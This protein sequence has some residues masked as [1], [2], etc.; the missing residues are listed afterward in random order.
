MS[1]A[2]QDLLVEFD[3][4]ITWITLNRPTKLN[5]LT[6]E[7]FETLSATL[8]SEATSSSKV[9]IIKGAGGN[10]S[11]GHDLS[12]DSVEVNEPGDSL[13]DLN[14]QRF[15]LSTFFQIFDHPKPVIAAVDGY[16]IA[17][18]TQI[19]P[20][21]D[22]VVTSETAAISGSPMIPLGGGFITPLL[23]YKI[24]ISR[25][26]LLSFI[27]GKSITGKEAV[28][29]GLAVQSVPS[30]ELIDTVKSLALEIARTPTSVLSLKKMAINRTLVAQGFRD[31]AYAGAE[32]DVVIHGIK[33][34][35]EYKNLIAKDG[36]K[37]TMARFK[38]GE[39]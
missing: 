2:S 19:L 31:Y 26:K 13:D 4:P 29:W 27:P 3:G 6:H 37:T 11:A 12:S 1:Q 25:A 33:E 36:L 16:C 7:M 20:F 8:A 30:A 9:I 28:E 14:R 34:V 35:N 5:A 39:I 21:C 24:G 10:F 23:A 17:G 22:F 15:Y 18:A 38:A 32:T